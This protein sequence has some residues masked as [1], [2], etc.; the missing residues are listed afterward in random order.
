MTVVKRILLLLSILALSACNSG[1]SAS[2]GSGGT[3]PTAS[4]VSTAVTANTLSNVPLNS[5][6]PVTVAFGVP[7]GGSATELTVTTG[8]ASLPSGWSV[9]SP[10][11]SC[12]SV[13]AQNPCDLT[14]TYDPST[15]GASGT[16]TLGFTYLDRQGKQQQGSVGIAYS[17]AAANSVTTS[18]APTG[19][20]QGVAGLT[21]TVTVTFESGDG[22]AASNLAL[23]TDLGSLPSGWSL[24]SSALPCAMVTGA[25]GCQL[26]LAYAPTAA[27]ASGTLTLEFSYTDDAGAARTGSVAIAYSAVVPAAVTAAATPVSA[28]ATYIGSTAAVGVAFSA[29][30]GAATNLQITSTLPAGWTF[31]GGTLPCAQV[32]GGTCQVTLNYAPVAATSASTFVLQ[33]A[34]TDNFGESRTGQLSIPYSAVPHIAY[35]TNSGSN[36]V[37]QCTLALTGALGNCT[38][39]SSPAINLPGG[40]TIDG[41]RAYIAEPGQSVSVCNV[42]S[43]GLSG[44]ETAVTDTNE[45]VSVALDG[46]IAFISN[47]GSQTLETCTVAADGTFSGCATVAA[48]TPLLSA[49]AGLTMQG[50]DLYITNAASSDITICGVTAGVISACVNEGLS[51]TSTNVA[52]AG[53]SAYLTIPGLNSVQ[54]CSVGSG[55]V[56]SACTD[57]GAGATFDFPYAIALFGG[58]AYVVNRNNNTISQCAVAANGQLS[59]CVVSGNGL[60]SPIDIAIQ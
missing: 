42:G 2:S 19:P 37:T 29:T 16:L 34:Y 11:F 51:S 7:N 36:S 8:L 45:P 17:S 22:T 48:A 44:C 18:V 33:Y 30:G 9:A 28:S 10:S 58:Y 54:Q 32:G 49:P 13:N 20:V 38:Q 6:T 4:T 23:V 15:A 27:A 55:G 24:Q 46:D 41:A 3:A 31:A 43:S 56:L 39:V 1:L 5:S 40:I 53:T 52:F 50:S 35:I 57:S 26:Q 59:A 21:N 60:N 12:A 14:L 25:G 47:Q